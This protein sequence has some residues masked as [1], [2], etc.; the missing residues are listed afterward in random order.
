MFDIIFT[1]IMSV[2]IVTL[3]IWLI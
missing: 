1:F 2:K 3:L